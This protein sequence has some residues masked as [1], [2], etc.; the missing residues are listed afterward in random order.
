MQAK[1]HEIYYTLF[2]IFKPYYTP[3]CISIKERKKERKN[4]AFKWQ[5]PLGSTIFIAIAKSFST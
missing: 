1:N 5:I 3:N 4:L 2:V